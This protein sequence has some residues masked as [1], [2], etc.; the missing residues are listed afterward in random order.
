MT[1]SLA[2]YR[3]LLLPAVQDCEDF[4]A[5][6]PLAHQR[7]LKFTEE[8]FHETPTSWLE[9]ASEAEW[10]PQCPRW[11]TRESLLRGGRRL[12]NKTAAAKTSPKLELEGFSYQDRVSYL[13]ISP[14]ISY[15]TD[16]TSH[17]SLDVSHRT[18]LTSHISLRISHTRYLTSHI[19]S[20]RS[21]P[22]SNR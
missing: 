3:T 5:E 22:A 19:S 12:L 14:H 13:H 1:S 16:R 11:G 2:P 21:H 6:R 20:R 8:A 17:I 10:N 4:R 9:K 15:F 18:C 7:E